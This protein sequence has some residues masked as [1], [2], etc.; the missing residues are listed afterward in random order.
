M[1]DRHS[2]PWSQLG[3]NMGNN[4]HD[5]IAGKVC[6]YCGRRTVLAD[7]SEIYGR[8]YGPI[9]LCRPCRA[10]VGC[11]KGTTMALGRLANEELRLAKNQAHQVF[12]RLWQENLVSRHEAYRIL[13]E[14]LAIN[15]DYAH[16][17]ML[18]VAQCREVVRL[19]SKV[20]SDLKS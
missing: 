7:S 19:F 18:D 2:G 9:Y 13:A 20:Y 16:I 14:E 12:D 4:L 11:H 6:P 8:S 10:Y 1:R 3:D 17:G 5:I 15:P